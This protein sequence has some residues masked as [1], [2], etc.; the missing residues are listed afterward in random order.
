[1]LALQDYRSRHKALSIGDLSCLVYAENHNAV[2]VA[3]DRNLRL[4]ATQKKIEVHG[5]L[6]LLDELIERGIITPTKA[7][8]ALKLM[9][10]NDAWL[11]L[12]EC[13][14]RMKSWLENKIPA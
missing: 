6:W 3:G 14:I 12:D 4:L 8:A 11:P 1:M 2:I 10:D 9:L 7:A 13:E 5:S